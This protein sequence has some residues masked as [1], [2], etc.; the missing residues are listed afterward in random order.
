ML[1]T[2]LDISADSRGVVTVTLNRPNVNNAYDGEMLSQMHTALDQL[3]ENTGA[4]VL[5]IKAAG[6]HFQAG[7]DLSWLREV[8]GGSA[9]EN[10][11]ASRLTGGV[12][13]RLN[14][15][16]IPVVS[17]VQGACFG[18]ATGILAASDVV[19]AADNAV[20]SIAE[21][22]WGLQAAVIIPQLNDAIS[23]RQVRRYALT[24]ERFDATEARRIG[25]VHEVVGPAELTDRVGQVVSSLLQNGPGALAETKRHILD[26][27]WGGFDG[28]TFDHLA[29]SHARTRQSEEAGEG[30]SSFVDR[31]PAA[32][33][34]TREME[35][36]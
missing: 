7:A 4:R 11:D 36:G 31:R 27:S 1:N 20:F 29:G 26:H 2:P 17:V 9:E 3:V 6:K 25:L 18:G 14:R 24:A 5:L 8:R 15:L 13:D 34:V 12:I 35:P 10:L 30:L 32:W 28:E 16:S 33:A 22:R 21:V 19:L 23:V